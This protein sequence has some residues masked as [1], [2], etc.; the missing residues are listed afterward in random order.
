M[1]KRLYQFFADDHHRI[2]KL[3]NKATEHPD[4]VDMNYYLQFR[5]QLL[6]HIKMEEK[7]LFKEAKKA[8]IVIMQEL[9]PQYRLEHG[10]LTALMVPPPTLSLIKV[11]R[12]ILKKHNI[13]EEGLEGLY[14]VCETLVQ[15]QTQ[16]LLNQLIATDEVPLHA[17]NP[18]PIALEAARRALM[19][20]GYDFDEIVRIG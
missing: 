10:A 19:R 2:D 12:Y 13:K 7:I 6:R 18:A 16:E 15:G 8:N 11:I 17:P 3:L 14:D 20:A 4:E 9:L 1:N 5:T